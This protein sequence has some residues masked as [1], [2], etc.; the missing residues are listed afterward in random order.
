MVEWSRRG[1]NQSVSNLIDRPSSTPIGTAPQSIQTDVLN[2]ANDEGIKLGDV[3]RV[4]RRRRKLVLT[5]AGAMF[6]LSM[7][8]AVY[9][10][11]ANPLF[12]GNFALLISDPLSNVGLEG[13][14]D[15]AKFEQLA[16][17]QAAYDIPTLIGV[18]RSPLLLQPLAEELNTSA[19]S[20]A[21][22]ITI[23]QPAV[24]R[25]GATG[26]LQVRVTGHQ[27]S[28]MDLTLKK[29]SA[30][31]LKAAQQQRQQRLQDGLKFLNQQAPA[32]EARTSQLQ[33]ELARFRVRNN[34]IE[35]NEEGAALKVQTIELDQKLLAL[36]NVR[37]RLKTV[38]KQINNGT[39]SVRSFQEAIGSSA[40]GNQQRDGLNIADRDE[41]LLEQFTKAETDLAAARTRYTPTS[42]V[43]TSLEARINQLEPLLRREQLEAVDLSIDLYNQ[44][45]DDT[46]EQRKSL[47]N[48]FLKQ[49]ELIKKFNTLQ[50][51]LIIA[52]TNLEGL[53]SARETFKLE[54]AQ[55]SVPWRVI[56]PPA[57]GRTPI[58]PSLSKSLLQG[59]L[60]SLISGIG[61]GLV[62]DRLDH[63]FRQ[64]GEVKE[65]LGLPLLGH[66]PHVDFFKGV[67]EDKRFL[68]Q[69]LD[70]SI[71]GDKDKNDKPDAR[72]RQQERYQRFFYQEAFRNL[73]TS[74]RFLNSDSPVRAIALTSSLPAEGKSLVNVLLAKTLSEMGQRVLLVDAD[75]RKP[76]MHTRLGLNNLSGLSNL[77]AE[78]DQHWSDVVQTVPT[79]DNWSVITAG[80]RPP[81]P[82]RLLS[83]KRM[84]AL[85][86]DLAQGT[87][88]DLVLF[89]TPPVLGLADAAL[90]AEHCD[91][92]MLLVSLNCVDRGLPKE[93][94]ARITSSGAPLLGVVTNAMKPEKQED[95]YGYGYA[96]TYAHY[97]DTDG[98]DTEGITKTLGPRS[99]SWLRA[100][101]ARRRQ[102]MRWIDS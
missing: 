97:V 29:L 54:L 9:Q 80:R 78:D 41:A 79:Y 34:L 86:A 14:G 100:I 71:N 53:A 45:L 90:V 39:L 25:R 64:P 10:R 61:V 23:S 7:I 27:P 85:V 87:D 74:L 75:L 98:S 70:R 49:P 43:V 69:E 51:K 101:Q 6:A 5:T 102:F 8:N 55:S 82:T 3:L 13:T 68:L 20:L 36:E 77:L 24:G 65:D 26:I 2:A 33:D 73:F 89:D 81:D 19:G 92:L 99:Q 63:V 96:A 35:P 59:M 76:Q 72:T 17:N 11:I 44:R 31:Y 48:Q 88:F 60:I 50:G 56:A 66:I 84:H 38:R 32:L 52:T 91:G 40:S 57:V 83:S 46:E 47:N 18:L 1:S 15:S 28:E 94:V 93:S 42:S 67:R 12:E 4:M 62:R 95:A 30:T 58:K 16:R 22:R 37:S 21:S